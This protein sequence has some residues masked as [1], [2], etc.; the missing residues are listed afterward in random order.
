LTLVKH[1]MDAHGGDVVI[2]SQP[3]EGTCV[4]LILPIHE[5]G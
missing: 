2:R 5:G 3:G 4:S 1:I